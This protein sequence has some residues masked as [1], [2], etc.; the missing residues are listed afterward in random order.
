M[1][2]AMRTE[3]PDL[4]GIVLWMLQAVFFA[5]WALVSLARDGGETVAA[6]LAVVAFGAA[7]LGYRRA[8]ALRSG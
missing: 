8:R 3:T 4:L 5:T 6:V 7:A 1:E 2:G